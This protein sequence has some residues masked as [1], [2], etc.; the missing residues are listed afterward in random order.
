[1]SNPITPSDTSEIRL[2]SSRE[3]QA[4]LGGRSYASI[5]RDER[6]GDFPQRVRVGKNGIGWY[7]HEL[8]A[9]LLSRP[10][11]QRDAS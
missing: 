4:R 9:Y 7:A 8:D 1:M 11:G 10:R 6:A 5:C 2:L 3:V